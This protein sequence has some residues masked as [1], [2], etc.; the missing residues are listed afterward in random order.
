MCISTRLDDPA[1]ACCSRVWY[2]AGSVDERRRH[3]LPR[4]IQSIVAVQSPSSKWERVNCSQPYLSLYKEPKTTHISAN[5]YATHMY[6]LVRALTHTRT[7]R[8]GTTFKHHRHTRRETR[9]TETALRG[10]G[11]ETLQFIRKQKPL[12]AQA[13]VRGTHTH[14]HASYINRFYA[15]R[16]CMCRIYRVG[17]KTTLNM[18]IIFY[19]HTIRW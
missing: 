3:H 8:T 19:L 2:L 10:W 6:T 17:W 11:T 1:R 5:L 15:G 4:C 13:Q 18:N 16:V 14:T 9:R 12:T 7:D